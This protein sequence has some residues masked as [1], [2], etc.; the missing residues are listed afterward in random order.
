MQQV[1]KN[2]KQTCITNN[3]FYIDNSNIN[4]S[5]LNNSKLHLNSKGSARLAVQMINFLMG[6][7]LYKSRKGNFQKSA[8][9]RMEILLTIQTTRA[10]SNMT[11][12]VESNMTCDVQQ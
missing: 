11:C 6:D 1:N 4:K 3:M 8:I 10:V 12:D 2:L 7:D 5:G 9:R